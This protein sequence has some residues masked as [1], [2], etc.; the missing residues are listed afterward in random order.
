MIKRN[1]TM[2]VVFVLFLTSALLAQE[3]KPLTLDECVQ[4]ALQN[5][6]SLKISGY[7][8]ESA[9]TSV[10]SARANFLPKINSS[11]S[12]GK[13]IQGARVTKMDVP[14]GEVD[15]E[16]GGVIYEEKSVLQDRTER[17]SHSAS[18]SLSQNIFDF[19]KSMNNLKSNKAG[20]TSM[21][22]SLKNTR[23]D[24]I[25]GVKQAFYELL[26]QYRLKEVYEEAV[27]VSNDEVSRVQT[28]MEIGLSSQAEVYQARV[29]L[30]NSKT[31]LLNQVNN[32]E[33]AKADLNNALGRFPSDPLEIVPENADAIFPEYSFEKASDLAVENN[34]YL[35][36]LEQEVK[37]NS[38]NIKY[39]K[40][41]YFP[42]IG[43]SASY[44]RSNTDFSRVYSSKLDQDFSI[45]MGVGV[46]LNIFNG[47]SDKASVQR[48]TIQ[49]N[50]AVENL[51]EAKRTLLS[52]VKQYYLQ[53]NAY[54]DIIEMN[55]LNIEAYEEN[56]RLQQEKRRVG[57][58]TELEVT[59]AQYD[60]TSA[61][62]DL[63]SAEFEAKTVIAQL[64]AA[65]GIIE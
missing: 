63:I 46:D 3:T 62:S 10:T 51:E 7:Q 31:T 9:E 36:A 5:N 15:S 60:L 47:F 2:L 6:S 64:E 38:Y 27:Q 54:K 37:A 25:A 23:N 65:L 13:Y 49:Y 17:N 44:S 39:A 57:S 24:V 26:K 48:N 55:K 1:A 58:G 14:T 22:H 59:Q 11:F 43:G 53:L 19:G 33:L 12:S 42:S 61:R 4:I 21:E 28:M 20:K 50:I 29:T 30:N 40:S 34:E 41:A 45:T 16:T 8:V 32:I 56:L 18:V 35:K 52:S